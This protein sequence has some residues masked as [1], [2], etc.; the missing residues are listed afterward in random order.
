MTALQ[1]ENIKCTYGSQT[2]LKDIS[3]SVSKGRMFIIIGPNGSGKTTLLRIISTFIKPKT[4]RIEI[5]GRPCQTYTRKSLAKVLAFVPQEVPPDFPFT[6]EEV[7]MMGRAPHIG[8]LGLESQKDKNIAAQAM[9][10]TQTD[11][12]ARRKLAY[13]SSGE[14]Q[15]VFISRAV[16]QEPE[17]MLLDE[18]TAALDL[19]HQVHI[20]DMMEKLKQEKNITIIMVSHDVNL[21]C[22]YADSLLLL[23]KGRMISMGSPQEVVNFKTLEQVYECVLMVDQSPLGKFPRVTLTPQKFLKR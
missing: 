23:K 17:I 5:C 21:A 9:K 20:M 14:R 7:V 6:V 10:F 19:G 3:F 13:L 4:G 2:V 1:L 12:L 16:C 11:H 18:P 22:M 15:R 8:L